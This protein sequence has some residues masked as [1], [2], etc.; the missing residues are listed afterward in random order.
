MSDPA[1]RDEA[2]ALLRRAVEVKPDG[3]AG[4]ANLA[5]ALGMAGRLAEATMAIDAALR[6]RPLDHQMWQIKASISAAAGDQAGAAAALERV[7]SL[8]GGAR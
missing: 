4:H 1:R 3:H 2:I 5:Q 8:R 6:L 7:E